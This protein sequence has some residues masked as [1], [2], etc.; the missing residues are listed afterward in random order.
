MSVRRP[1]A[2]QYMCVRLNST[3]VARCLPIDIEYLV[4]RCEDA[5]S[6]SNEMEIWI[7]YVQACDMPLRDQTTLYLSSLFD[8]QARCIRRVPWCSASTTSVY[9]MTRSSTKSCGLFLLIFGHMW[10]CT[11]LYCNGDWINFTRMIVTCVQ[12]QTLYPPQK[13]YSLFDE[14]NTSTK[15]PITHCQAQRQCINEVSH[16]AKL[17]VVFI[18]QSPWW[19]R[20]MMH[21]AS[22]ET[23]FRVLC[24]FKIVTG[25]LRPNCVASTENA[26]S[27]RWN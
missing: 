25:G 17:Q 2:G 23:Q 26:C 22:I 10:W 16:L 20:V 6:C 24:T 3:A 1:M 9:K 12:T 21:L 18:I 5:S 27:F 13:I 11:L 19:M 14:K 8:K 7:V 4:N 15:C